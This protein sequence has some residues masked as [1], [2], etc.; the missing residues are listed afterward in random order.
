MAEPRV[1]DPTTRPHGLALPS[2]TGAPVLIQALGSVSSPLKLL[3]NTRWM[4]DS[5]YCP[6]SGS[7]AA[8]GLQRGG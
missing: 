8:A 4:E 3:P 1:R 7:S 2:C 5:T 6:T